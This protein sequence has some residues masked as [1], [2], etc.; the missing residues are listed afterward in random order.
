[1][2][3]EITIVTN[4][5]GGR[6]LYLSSKLY[7]MVKYVVLIEY[8]VIDNG[9]YDAVAAAAAA[10]ADADAADDDDDEFFS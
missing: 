9:D 4:K 7:F 6:L 1:M 3:E 10:V 2:L 5:H 8:R